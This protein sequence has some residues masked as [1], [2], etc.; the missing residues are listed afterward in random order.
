MPVLHDA[1]HGETIPEASIVVDFSRSTLSA[2]TPL[3][4]RHFGLCLQA[5]LWA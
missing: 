3:L 4:P 5:R 1:A 2:P